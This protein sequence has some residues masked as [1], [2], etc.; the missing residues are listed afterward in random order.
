[1]R[2][3][4]FHSIIVDA[5]CCAVLLSLPGCTGGT[6]DVKTL[7]QHGDGARWGEYLGETHLTPRNVNFLNFGLLYV[8]NVDGDADGQVLYMDNVPTKHNGR[9]NLFFVATDTNMVYAF[10]IDDTSTDPN[11]G[12]VFATK[13]SD[14]TND[15]LRVRL[16]FMR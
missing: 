15:P 12:L 4:G 5:L 8:R 13:K 3:S 14:G 6:T 9:K 1:M 7:S 11:A 2:R 16:V 10:N